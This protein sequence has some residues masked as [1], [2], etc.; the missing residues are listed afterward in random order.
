MEI[1]RTGLKN[2]ESL[3]REKENNLIECQEALTR[4][5]ILSTDLTNKYDKFVLQ[6][7][8]EKE[9]YQLQHSQL[10]DKVITVIV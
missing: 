2:A 3:L 6:Y 5:K 1:C 7:E 10:H 9:N 8:T 4:E